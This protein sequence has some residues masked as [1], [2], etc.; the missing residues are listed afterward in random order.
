M[1]A[2]NLSAE[3]WNF[4]LLSHH[5]HDH[6]LIASPVELCVEDALPGPQIKLA[7]GDWHNYFVMNE[8]S[9]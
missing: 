1:K 7:I 2:A 3:G 5:L 4:E 9:F 6:A 8:Q